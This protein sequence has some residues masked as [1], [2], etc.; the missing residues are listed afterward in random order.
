MFLG[1]FSFLSLVGVAKPVCLILDLVGVVGVYDRSLAVEVLILGVL[2]EPISEP[3]GVLI[4]SSSLFPEK[5]SA[6]PPLPLVNVYF[7]LTALVLESQP[8]WLPSSAKDE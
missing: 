2:D 1:V 5:I 7:L 4:T 8:S 3:F 6:S